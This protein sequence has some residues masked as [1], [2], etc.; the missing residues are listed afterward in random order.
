MAEIVGMTV[1]NAL[2]WM[3]NDMLIWISLKPTSI[4]HINDYIIFIWSQYSNI[5][6]IS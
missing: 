3:D 1:S 4:K 5:D 2:S 6:K